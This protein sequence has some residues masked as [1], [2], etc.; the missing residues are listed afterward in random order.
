MRTLRTT[1]NLNADFFF[2]TI[3]ELYEA[4]QSDE[5]NESKFK[6]V[7]FNFPV[8]DACMLSAIAKRFG[9]SNAAF[10]G[11]VFAEG[12]RMLFLALS[13]DD[14]HK[15]A[16]E[17]DAEAN[18]Y[19]ESKGWSSTDKNGKKLPP[20]MSHWVRHAEMCDEVDAKNDTMQEGSK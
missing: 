3:E 11:E 16:V 7:T 4:E 19:L 9:R 17:A 13:S 8:E 1:P 14:R 18:A 6:T 20:N 5:T 2:R 15:L 12:V 10:G